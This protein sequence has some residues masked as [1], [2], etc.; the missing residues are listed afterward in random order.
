MIIYREKKK[1]MYKKERYEKMM[2]LFL[3]SI[4]YEIVV[5]DEKGNLRLMQEMRNTC[6]GKDY[7]EMMHWLI[8]L[9]DLNLLLL[10]LKVVMKQVISSS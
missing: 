10:D 2:F 9:I 1:Y 7:F 8:F 5:V 6:L 4:R 3:F